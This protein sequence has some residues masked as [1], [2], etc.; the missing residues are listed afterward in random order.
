MQLIDSTFESLED[1]LE[2]SLGGYKPECDIYKENLENITQPSYYLDLLTIMMSCLIN[3]AHL[4][5]AIQF[6]DVKSVV[7]KI[8]S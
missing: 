3:V 6:Y 7:K 1:Y 4:I 2:C 5:Y 8:C